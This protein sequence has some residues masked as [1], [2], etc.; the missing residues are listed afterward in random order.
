MFFSVEILSSFLTITATFAS[1]FTYITNVD[2]FLTAKLN[3]ID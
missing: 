2:T 1:V 3:I